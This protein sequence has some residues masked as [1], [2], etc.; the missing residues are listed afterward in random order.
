MKIILVDRRKYK[1]GFGHPHWSYLTINFFNV[2]FI[3]PGKQVNNRNAI[4]AV[5]FTY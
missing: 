4:S 5:D 2:F 3:W 1:I